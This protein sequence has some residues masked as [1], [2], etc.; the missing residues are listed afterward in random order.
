MGGVGV[1]RC[2]DRGPETRTHDA[3]HISAGGS[4]YGTWSIRGGKGLRRFSVLK[5]DI[6][7]AN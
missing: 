4:R 7:L 2:L 5:I 6:Q 3:G 1:A